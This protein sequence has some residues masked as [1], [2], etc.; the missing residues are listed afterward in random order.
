MG[1]VFEFFLKKNSHKIE[2]LGSKHETLLTREN[3]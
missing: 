1:F 2:F 3:K